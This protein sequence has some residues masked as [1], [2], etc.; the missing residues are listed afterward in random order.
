MIFQRVKMGNLSK[1]LYQLSKQNIKPHS[2][3]RHL[4][5]KFIT[6]IAPTANEIL[7]KVRL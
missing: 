6:S 4:A 1:I 3:V 5:H 7:T 2:L